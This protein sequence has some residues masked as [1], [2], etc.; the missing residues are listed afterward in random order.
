MSLIGLI[1]FYGVVI[2]AVISVVQNTV[3]HYLFWRHGEFQLATEL[4]T[5]SRVFALVVVLFSF[6]LG[7]YESDLTA[8]YVGCVLLPFVFFTRLPLATSL[9]RALAAA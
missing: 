5:Q 6:A 4:E 8:F 1:C 2:C 9:K 3:A 7:V